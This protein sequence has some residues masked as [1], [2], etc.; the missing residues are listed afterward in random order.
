MS[1][2]VTQEQFTQ[3]LE[4]VRKG[5]NAVSQGQSEIK[6]SLNGIDKRLTKV[7]TNLEDVNNSL[8]D[9]DKRL[10]KVEANGQ[11]LDKRLSNVETSVQKLPDVSEKFGELKN[12]R[13]IAF[14][15]IAAVVGWFAR[16]GKF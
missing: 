3:V 12:W 7:E 2:Y 10:I 5:F 4:E 8:N 9:I 1:N 14:I 11:S 16:G 13:Q 6:A 15:I